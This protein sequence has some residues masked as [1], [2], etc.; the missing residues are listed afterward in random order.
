MYSSANLDA[1]L[2]QWAQKKNLAGVSACMLGPDGERYDFAYG[3]RDAA[4]TPVDSDTMFGIASMSKSIT[5][6]CICILACE[7][8]LSLEDPVCRYF[9]AFAVPGQPREAVTLRHLMMHTAGIPPMEPLEWSIAINS[10]GRDESEWAQ[11]MRKSAPNK[12]DKIEQI[13]DYIAH[14]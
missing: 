6:L 3:Q 5:S 14:C 4:G 7:G 8:K 11:A 12:M 9:P 10:P 2:T 13:I 1:Y